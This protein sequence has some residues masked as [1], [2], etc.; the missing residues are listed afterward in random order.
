MEGRCR[1]FD[2]FASGGGDRFAFDDGLAIADDVR[3]STGDCLDDDDD[4]LWSYE[5]GSAR[6]RFGSAAEFITW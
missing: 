6:V 3:G 2:S 4:E 5:L 1:L